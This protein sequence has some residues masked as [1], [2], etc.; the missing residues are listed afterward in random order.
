MESLESEEVLR[1]SVQD[2][3]IEEGGTD[4][5][6]KSTEVILVDPCLKPCEKPG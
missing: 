4:S 5:R 6:P 2:R 1:V 3:R